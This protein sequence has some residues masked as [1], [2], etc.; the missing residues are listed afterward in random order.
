MQHL[1]LKI[2]G[3]LATV[4]LNRPAKKNALSEQLFD[5]L[6]GAGLLLQQTPNLRAVILTGAGSDFCS[7]IDLQFLQSLL[8]RLDICVKSFLWC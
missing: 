5:D 1:D 4:T 6:Y 2:E 8:P 7:G 3:G